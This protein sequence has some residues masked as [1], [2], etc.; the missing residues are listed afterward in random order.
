M[1]SNT[2]LPDDGLGDPSNGTVPLYLTYLKLLGLTLGVPLVTIPALMVITIIVKIRNQI[3]I[4]NINNIFFANLLVADIGFALIHWS[5]GGT[6][7]ILYLCDLPNLDC[8][9]AHMLIRVSVLASRLMFLPLT[10]NRLINVAFPFSY[11]RIMNLKIVFA[12]LSCLWLLVLLI[13]FISRV[14]HFDIVPAL[15]ECDPKHTSPLTPLVTVGSLFTSIVV[16]TTTSVYLH[17]KIIKSNRFFHSVKRNAVEERKSIQAGRL[18]EAL[19]EQLKPTLSVFAAG[20]IDGAFSLIGV[21]IIVTALSLTPSTFLYTK[22]FALI[23]L[24]YCQSMSHALV[25]GFHN[26]NIHKKLLNYLNFNQKHS[27]VTVL[28][29]K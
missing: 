23:P 12:I 14:N 5:V 20:G 29:G 3:N 13:S 8:K 11:K 21:I 25:Y 26:K 2:T 17:Y 24:Q 27:K 16:I 4:N 7:I 18:V 28:N 19:Q 1:D 10:I 6:M 9:I 22:Q 15:G